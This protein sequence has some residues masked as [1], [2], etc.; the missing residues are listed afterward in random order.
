MVDQ[1]VNP[2][3]FQGYFIVF[4]YLFYNLK[5][6]VVCKYFK[7]NLFSGSWKETVTFS[8]KISQSK[9]FANFYM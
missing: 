6:N 7:I 2:Q 3:K 4:V 5:N 8:L 9:I 1:N